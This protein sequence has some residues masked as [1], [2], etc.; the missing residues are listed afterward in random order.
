MHESLGWGK[1]CSEKNLSHSL[2]RALY[3][4][5]SLALSGAEAQAHQ[6]VALGVRKESPTE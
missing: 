3:L 5:C 4:S 1:V 6:R 2:F